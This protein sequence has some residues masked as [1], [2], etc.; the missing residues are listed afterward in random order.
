MKN[1]IF[2][3]MFYMTLKSQLFVELDGMGT[4]KNLH[5]DEK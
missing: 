5:Y 3:V 4:E 1:L 2:Y